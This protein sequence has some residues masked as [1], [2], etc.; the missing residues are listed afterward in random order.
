MLRIVMPDDTQPT[1]R[2]STTTGTIVRTEA[3]SEP[4]NS[5]E[6]GSG[7]SGMVPR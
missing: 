3:P 6:S 5:S 2:S 1:T 4:T 7:A